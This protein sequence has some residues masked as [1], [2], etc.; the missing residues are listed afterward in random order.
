MQQFKFSNDTILKLSG[1][2]PTIRYLDNSFRYFESYTHSEQADITCK[3]APIKTSTERKLGNPSK[4]FSR[5]GSSFILKRHGGAWT[6]DKNWE[7]IRMSPDLI[8]DRPRIAIEFALRKKYIEDEISLVHG[9][10]VRINNEI[11]IMPAWRH[12]GKTNIMLSL[13]EQGGDYLADDRVWIGSD[14]KVLAYPSNIHLMSYNYKS[15]PNLSENLI[16]RFRAI[17]S[18]NINNIVEDNSSKIFRG[19]KQVNN[20]L[21]SQND[22]IEPNKLYQGT[23]II[24]S[25]TIDRLLLLQSTDR[26]SPKLEKIPQSELHRALRSISFYE[27]DKDL[28]EIGMTHDTLFPGRNSREDQIKGLIE[29]DSDVFSTLT[30]SFDCYKLLVPQQESWSQK[31]KQNIL[32]NIL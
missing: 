32:E 22:W 20:T 31:T 10:A 18:S 15:F 12:T 19:I 16:D 17:L 25:G 21:I 9:S 28:L 1:S 11:I 29:K 23:D 26:S 24:N 8:D 30:S 6:L 2:G 14:G 5:S 7:K 13:L 3:I 4:N 27:W